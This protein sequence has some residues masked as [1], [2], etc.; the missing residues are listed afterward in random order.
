MPVLVVFLCCMGF[1]LVFGLFFFWLQLPTRFQD[2]PKV[3]IFICESAVAPGNCQSDP[4]PSFKE[5][6]HLE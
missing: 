4:Q 5:V 6:P 2:K 1:V 3:L